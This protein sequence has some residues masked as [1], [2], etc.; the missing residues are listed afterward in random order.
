[1][2]AVDFTTKQLLAFTTEGFNQPLTALA[3]PMSPVKFVE[4]VI[5]NGQI[6]IAGNGGVAIF[7]LP[8]SQGT[9]DFSNFVSGVY[10]NVL[11]RPAAPTE[12][13]FVGDVAALQDGSNTPA[14]LIAAVLASNEYRSDLVQSFYQK[15]LGRAGSAA[16]VTNWVNAL[17][18][19]AAIEQI[20]LD[21]VSSPEYFA[22]QGLYAP[23]WIAA[24]Y[25]D[26]LGR[27][28][29]SAELA[30]WELLYNQAEGNLAA[31]AQGFLTSEEYLSDVI[32]SDYWLYLQRAA[33]QT[34]ADVQ[35]RPGCPCSDGELAM[36]AVAASIGSGVEAAE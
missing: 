36:K 18:S 30:G 10:E 34:A 1:M 11:N 19:G 29:S 20:M 27:S 14:G 5:A 2:W 23:S 32:F 24:L 15:Y 21:F 4:P 22:K 33:W 31:V 28:A 35:E 16:E 7:G 13:G 8:T 9:D 17:N 12:T 3:L 6:I 26:L 25:S